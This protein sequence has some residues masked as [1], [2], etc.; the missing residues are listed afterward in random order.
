MR[1]LN[2]TDIDFH[3]P[4]NKFNHFV[5]VDNLYIGSKVFTTEQINFLQEI[6]IKTVIDLKEAHET[7][8]NDKDEFSKHGFKYLNFPIRDFRELDF[9]KL[10]AFSKL[11]NNNEK[12]LIYCISG[13][14]AAAVLAL[15]SCLICGHPKQR[16]FD[17]AEKIG[18]NDLE[19]KNIIIDLLN[20]GTLLC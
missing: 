2:L 8:Y 18:L 12:V 4:S 9:K 19:T 11:T 13:N 16:S 5:R 1:S 6:N 20:R 14:R 3:M 10:Q 17:F 15:Q 7:K